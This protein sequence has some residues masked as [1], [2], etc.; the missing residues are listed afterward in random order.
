[1]S[2]AGEWLL[3]GT[4]QAEA[5]NAVAAA[6]RRNCDCSHLRP[7]Y[8]IRFHLPAR[9]LLGGCQLHAAD[10]HWCTMVDSPTDISRLK[11]RR[12]VD[13]RLFVAS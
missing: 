13:G 5:C 4:L 6:E 7:C 1:M 11:Q 3:L 2:G 9:S 12:T 10:Q 8:H